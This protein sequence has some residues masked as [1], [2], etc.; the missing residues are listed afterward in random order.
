MRRVLGILAV[1]LAVVALPAASRAA[2]S[3][4]ATSAPMD[5][6]AGMGEDGAPPC[7]CSWNA[8]P[9]A[10]AALGAAPAPAV[11]LAESP[12]PVVTVEE[13]APVAAPAPVVPRARAAPLFLLHSVLL[14]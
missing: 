5:C 10:P 12:L 2:S 1:L 11:V 14:V 8:V 7:H 3:P 9:P 4:C 6:C 13:P